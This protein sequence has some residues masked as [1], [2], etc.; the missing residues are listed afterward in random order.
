MR[1]HWSGDT[2]NKAT[3]SL[4]RLVLC[5]DPADPRSVKGQGTHLPDM[6]SEVPKAHPPCCG[7]GRKKLSILTCVPPEDEC[8]AGRALLAGTPQ[9]GPR[10][11]LTSSNCDETAEHSC[12]WRRGS[13]GSVSPRLLG[14]TGGTAN[15]IR[16][17]PI[18]P[19]FAL[20]IAGAAGGASLM[21]M[22]SKKSSSRSTASSSSPSGRHSSSSSSLLLSSSGPAA[23]S[24][25]E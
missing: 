3:S 10:G 20:F 19:A 25:S 9:I 11:W 24:S 15:P 13:C 2:P 7:R 5:G 14:I 17:P 6:P 4:P 16:H 1:G 23:S 22:I 21:P 18:P 12:I 8:G